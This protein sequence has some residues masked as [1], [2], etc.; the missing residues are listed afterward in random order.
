MNRLALKTMD[1]PVQA[2]LVIA[3]AAVLLIL[4]AMIAKRIGF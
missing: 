2:L 1:S 3:G 4:G